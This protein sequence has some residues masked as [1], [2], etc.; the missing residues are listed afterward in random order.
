MHDCALS[1]QAGAWCSC[2]E[3]HPDND[4]SKEKAIVF[5]VVYLNSRKVIPRLRVK[6]AIGEIGIAQVL[7]NNTFRGEEYV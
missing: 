7:L 3:D 5:Q 2:D 4:M 1:Q 6:V